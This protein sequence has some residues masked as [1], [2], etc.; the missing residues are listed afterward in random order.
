LAR[1]AR[2]RLLGFGLLAALVA[3]VAM[4]EVAA[5]LRTLAWL[6]PELCIGLLAVGAW[7]V[8]TAFWFVYAVW[9]PMSLLGLGFYVLFG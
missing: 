7:A 4:V 3:L 1:D 6:L 2:W 5:A 8:G 9:L